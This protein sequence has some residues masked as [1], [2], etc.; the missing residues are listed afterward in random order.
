VIKVSRMTGKLD[1]LAA[2]N[3]NTLSNEFCQQQHA[4]GKTICGDCYSV[5]MLQTH[6]QNCVDPWEQNSRAL[7]RP[8]TDLELAA[9]TDRLVNLRFVRF[10]GHGE[11]QNRDHLRNFVRIAAA[12][13]G[14]TF[15]LWTK[16]ADL[17]RSVASSGP[18]PANLILIYS[19][20]RTDRVR[21]DP[22]KH[23][24]KVFNNTRAAD[25]RDNCTGRKCLDCLNCYQATGPVSIIEIVK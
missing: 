24:H 13:P 15:T 9:L 8:I 19:N 11:L 18:I 4:A 3:T 12:L 5:R 23:F 6:R 14:T 20:P 16:R 1:G 2:I 22:P 17:V 25:P 10:H 21:S 7:A